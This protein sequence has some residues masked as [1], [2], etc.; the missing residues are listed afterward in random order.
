MS[1][2]T[3]TLTEDDT[4]VCEECGITEKDCE[5]EL[6]LSQYLG[7]T[8]CPDCIPCD[9]EDEEVFECEKCEKYFDK[10]E[11]ESDLCRDC[12]KDDDDRKRSIDI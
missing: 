6:G 3:Y 9:D 8:L 10:C 7:R 5:T 1:H 11:M 12:K 4:V 2:T